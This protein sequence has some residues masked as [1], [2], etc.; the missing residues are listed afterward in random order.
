MKPT[1]K[2]RLGDLLVQESL[3]T[4]EQLDQ[5]L[6]IQKNQ[7]VYKPLGEICIELK[8]ISRAKLNRILNKYQK[9]IQLGELLINLE[10][11]TPEQL[12]KGLKQQKSERGKLGDIL[13]KKGFITE[14]SLLNTLTIQMGVPKI[15]PDF[16]LIDKKLLGGISEE[17][18]IK[19]EVLPAFKEDDVLTVIMGN[20][21]D[22]ETI[23][24]LSNIFKCK[25]EPAIA[26]SGDIKAAIIQHYRR[27]RLA[28]QDVPEEDTKDLIIGDTNLSRE[29]GNNIVGIVDYIVTNAIMEGASD[30]HLEPKEK[31]L[32]VRYRVDGILRHK[33][34]LPISL[35]PS[36]VSRIKIL[37]GLDIAEKRRHQDGRIEARV[38]DK[39]VDL[40]ISVYAS[41]Y[42]ES[43]VIR[44]LHRQTEL[45]ELDALGISPT[46]KARFQQML[47]QPSGIIL[48]TGPTGSGKTTTLY[49]CLNYLNDGQ[50]AIITVEDP[51]EYTIQG[52]VQGQLNPKLGITYSDFLKSMM[53][54]DPDVIMV[55]EIRD[56][57]AAEAVI[58]AALTGHKVFSTFHTDD[59]TGALLRLM[60]MG[61]DTFLISSTVVSILAQ[62]LV[63]VLC[64]HCSKPYVPDQH[65]L[66]SFGVSSTG[67]DKFKFYQPVGCSH[68]ADT[69][70]KG[71]TAIHE[72][73]FVN[74]AIRNAILARKTSSQIRLIARE[75]SNLISMR[76][77]GFYK[78][79][80]GITS[81]E[82]AVRVVF[83]NESNEL[84]LRSAEEVV[85]LCE[86]GTT[87]TRKQLD[88]IPISE[89]IPLEEA[90]ASVSITDANLSVLE[91]EVYRIR[92]DATTIETETDKITDFFKAYQR[93]MQEMGN[94]LDSDLLNDFVDFI[95]YTVKRL[96][97]SLKS[98]FV[99]FF[100]RV[101]DEKVKILLETLTPQRLSSLPF[102]RSKEKSLRLINFLMPTSGVEKALMVE[103]NYMKRRGPSQKKTSLIE[104]LKEE[105]SRQHEVR[106]TAHPKSFG[107]YKKHV[108]EL[109]LSGYLG[110]S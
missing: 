110:V 65:L 98:E 67:A 88:S 87:V 64:P 9:S 54:Q 79:T 80:K 77:D 91:G 70:F 78:A 57:I 38:M 3:I 71:R 109:E 2:L 97:I 63:R 95:I 50:R 12:E 42:G 76:E 19:Y 45:I 48:V 107:L 17:F 34:D 27:V 66:A 46:N 73:L 10:L 86:K 85:A 75:Q 4:T 51:V 106:D 44:I 23:R 28:N 8:F 13:I 26:L 14:T 58:Q 32:R 1:N 35:A 55:G 99:E 102:R 96:E 11:I 103:S 56:A 39:E 6:L 100:L 61:I 92:F 24:E 108:E 37:C 74:D 15:V 47:K 29:R 53:R 40:R 60:D 5:V 30:I 22:E 7:K 93:S 68:C 21:L 69:G 49:A 52:V 62:R 104:F 41:T 105:E 90:E 81:L 83:Y 33:T 82:E 43:V 31:S 89:K 84:S 25:I 20:P 16:H 59:T 72:L 18:L 36:L 101:K 94:A